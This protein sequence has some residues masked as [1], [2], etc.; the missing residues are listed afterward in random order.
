MSL[1]D[2]IKKSLGQSS[3]DGRM[4]QKYSKPLNHILEGHR[5]CKILK[6]TSN[7]ISAGVSNY[8]GSTLFKI[9]DDPNRNIVNIEY[10]VSKNPVVPNFLLNFSFPDSKDQEEMMIEIAK[11]IQN[12]MM[13]LMK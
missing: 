1:K 3:S 7:Y 13:C 12:K 6:E 9:H 2:F 5:G 11:G 4:R 8:G 10:E